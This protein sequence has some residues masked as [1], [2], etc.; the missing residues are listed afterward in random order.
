VTMVSH[1][2]RPHSGSRQASLSSAAASAAVGGSGLVFA[3]VGAYAIA[4]G[5]TPR[6]PQR[7]ARS[8]APRMM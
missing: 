3:G 2:S 6:Y 1:S 5:L 7:T 8:R 4:A